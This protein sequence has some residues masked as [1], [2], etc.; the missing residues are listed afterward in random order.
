MIFLLFLSHLINAE[1]IE[2]EKNSRI[3]NGAD[4][5]GY[6]WLAAIVTFSDVSCGGALIDVEWVLTAAHCVLGRDDFDSFDFVGDDL[7]DTFLWTGK[8]LIGMLDKTENQLEHI[9]SRQ[10][11][12]AHCNDGFTML[13]TNSMNNDICLLRLDSAISE[14]EVDNFPFSK[15]FRQNKA[16]LPSFTAPV[17]ES[18]IVAGWGLLNSGDTDKPDMLQYTSVPKVSH[19]QCQEWYAENSIDIDEKTHL[20]FGYED[21]RTD[22]CQGDSGGPIMC[23]N[24]DQRWEAHGIVSFGLECAYKERPGVYT[25]VNHYKSWI[26][27]TIYRVT[28]ESSFNTTC[29]SFG[30]S[31]SSLLLMIVRMI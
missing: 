14:N 3:V 11:I 20:C 13:N 17:N 8:V 9:V 12:S 16:C 1:N 4:S 21:G 7:L 6:P 15:N 29:S 27:D 18:C 25:N 22:S 19:A 28:P 24:S 5:T 23:Q 30:L 26:S 2:V 31:V 10:I